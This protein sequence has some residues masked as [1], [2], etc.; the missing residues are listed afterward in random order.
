MPT[1]AIWRTARQTAPRFLSISGRKLHRFR[2]SNPRNR[3][4]FLNRIIVTL[5]GQSGLNKTVAMSPRHDAPNWFAS[6]G[7]S[8]A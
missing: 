2:K 6:C 5:A 7:Y 3:A 1:L 4:V 8:F